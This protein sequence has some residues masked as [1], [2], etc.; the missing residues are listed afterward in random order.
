MV[1]LNSQAFVS[2]NQEIKEINIK[3]KH[4]DFSVHEQ[5]DCGIGWKNTL[6]NL[7]LIF[8]PIL[9]FWL[10]L[11]WLNVFPN[12]KLLI[13]FNHLINSIYQYQPFYTSAEYG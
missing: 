12:S 3:N 13:G 10:I 1:S 6:N 9:L 2:L 7:R 4:V 11:P 5:W 8:Q